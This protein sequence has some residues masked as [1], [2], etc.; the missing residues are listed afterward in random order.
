LP[1]VRTNQSGQ[2]ETKHAD[3]EVE[4]HG[5]ARE[6]IVHHIACHLAPESREK[7]EEEDCTNI[8][9]GAATSAPDLCR[10]G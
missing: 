5:I 1:D 7:D 4:H 8:F 10:Q 9:F 3:D 2:V 6:Q